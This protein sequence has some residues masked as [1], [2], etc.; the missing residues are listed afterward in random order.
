[1]AD[2]NPPVGAIKSLGYKNPGDENFTVYW[3]QFW[4]THYYT[5]CIDKRNN[6][7]GG[8]QTTAIVLMIGFSTVYLSF[9][10]SFIFLHLKFKINPSKAIKAQHGLVQY[11]GSGKVTNKKIVHTTRFEAT[12][13]PL[14]FLI[15][16]TL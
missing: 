11:V 8:A 1:V 10:Y 13:Y 14:F 5:Y 3:N 2:G 16:H 7:G 12:L 4:K 9:L 15:A 6:I